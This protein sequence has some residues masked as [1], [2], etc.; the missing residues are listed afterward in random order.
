[1]LA[2]T[3]RF[4]D[5]LHGRLPLVNRGDGTYDLPPGVKPVRVVVLNEVPQTPANAVWN[6]FSGSAERVAAREVLRD[7]LPR[8]PSIFQEL[9]DFYQLERM[10]MPYTLED[11]DRETT[12]K[13]LKRVPP[14]WVTDVLTPEQRMA[15]LDPEQRL[16]GLTAEQIE[17]YLAQLKARAPKPTDQGPSGPS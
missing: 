11:F 4:P 13:L 15:G 9:R 3:M 12:R 8:W 6:L 17:A 16:A 2:A 7:R 10:A 1:L 5:G 14:E